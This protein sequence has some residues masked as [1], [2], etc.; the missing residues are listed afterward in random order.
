MY[1]KNNAVELIKKFQQLFTNLNHKEIAERLVKLVAAKAIV[2]RAVLVVERD[3]HLYV[4]TIAS[5]Q[6]S[7]LLVSGIST[8]LNHLNDLTHHHIHQIFDN[9][10]AQYLY[11]DK[12]N[13][14][15]LL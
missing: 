9:G 7:D 5:Q 8:S 3:S 6:D 15:E 1:N 12:I 2:S 4:E 10:K 13:K 11:Y 14:K